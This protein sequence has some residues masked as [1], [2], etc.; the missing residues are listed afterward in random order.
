MTTMYGIPNCDTIR[1]ARK[2]LAD[3]GVEYD[4]HDYKKSGAPAAKLKSWVAE[5]GWEALLNKSGM[6]F[7]KL[8]PE[9]K[10]DLNETKALALMAEHPSMIRRPVLEANGQLLIGFDPQRYQQVLMT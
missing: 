1:K 9:Q 4:F 8:P 6:T 2:W 3:A 7:R 5:A 10:A